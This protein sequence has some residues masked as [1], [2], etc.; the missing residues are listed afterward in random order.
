MTKE[1]PT[2][3]EEATA[4]EVAQAEALAR[5]LEEDG[6][7]VEGAD[8]VLETAAF[9]RHVRTVQTGAAQPG[10]VAAPDGRTLAAVDARHPRLRWRW[11]VPALL[12][13]AAAGVLLLGS[14]EWRAV[15]EAPLP[16]PPLALLQAQAKAAQG[17]AD[18][19]ALDRLMRDY[20]ASVYAAL[21]TNGGGER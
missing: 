5:A 15:P 1:G 8:D 7:R 2:G 3:E 21:A 20:R 13:P 17:R 9:L 4:E 18:L 11:L 10:V 12:V 6:R 19:A 16:A 14:M